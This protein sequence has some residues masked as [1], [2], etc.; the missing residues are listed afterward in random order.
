M[1]KFLRVF[2]FGVI[3]LSVFLAGCSTSSGPVATPGGSGG[4]LVVGT[5]VP[6]SGG[7]GALFEMRV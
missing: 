5:P 7:G 1:S 2:V 4:S 6:A 3:A